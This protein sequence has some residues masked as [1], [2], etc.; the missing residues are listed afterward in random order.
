LPKKRKQIYKQIR[1]PLRLR[2]LYG[3]WKWWYHSLVLICFNRQSVMT[4]SLFQQ[5][6]KRVLILLSL[7]NMWENCL[8]G[9]KILNSLHDST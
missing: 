5:T 7:Y 8:T 6:V 1:N 2:G 3:T 9:S 4:W